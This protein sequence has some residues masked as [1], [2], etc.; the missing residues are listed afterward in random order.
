[1]TTLRPPRDHPDTTNVE[2][3]GPFVYF[4]PV[5]SMEIL[6][7]NKVTVAAAIVGSLVGMPAFFMGL[8]QPQS[9]DLVFMSCMA[10]IIVAS[11]FASLVLLECDSNLRRT[12]RGV[13][14]T[15]STQDAQSS[16]DVFAAFCKKLEIHP[17]FVHL[18]L[19]KTN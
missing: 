14:Q 3:Y 11:I 6:L 12:L 9:D 10:V 17:E 15:L 18:R 5:S 16:K 7:K 13:L 8:V 19:H 4:L 1:M 2:Y